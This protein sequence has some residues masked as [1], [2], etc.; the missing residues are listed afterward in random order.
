MLNWNTLYPHTS[1]ELF[2][3][4]QFLPKNLT[5]WCFCFILYKVQNNEGGQ[6]KYRGVIRTLRI[7]FQEEGMRG[8]YT[9]LTP[10]IHRQLGFATVKIG[11]YDNTK[12]L[13]TK[14]RYRGEPFSSGV[15][16]MWFSD[17][18]CYS[19]IGC[20]TTGEEE[21]SYCPVCIR[22]FAGVTTGALSVSLAQPTDVVKV[23]MQAQ[24]GANKG[25]YSGTMDAYRK[26]Y[27]TEGVKGLWRGKANYQIMVAF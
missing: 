11:C 20:L 14:L 5:R 21:P 24:F 16:E 3:N 2:K 18:H 19:C 13:Y 9:G 4:L 15:G 10:A 23:R 17:K 25:R 27:S 12:H 22:V 1:L 26:V 6:P 7:M 8:L